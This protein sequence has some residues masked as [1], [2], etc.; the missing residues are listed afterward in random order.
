[1]GLLLLTNTLIAEY[2]ILG[3]FI[4]TM[5]MN[6]SILLPLPADLVVFSA[7]AL[8][9]SSIFF[10][11]LAIGIVA[12]IGSAIG[13]L[14]SWAV[15]WETDVLV[16]KKRHGKTYLLVKE[17]FTRYGFVGIA[18]FAL[19]PLPLDVM[20]LFA[21]AVRYSPVKYFTATL[22]GKIPRAI[23]LAYAGLSGMVIVLKF[24]QGMP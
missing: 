13:E 16:L 7:G 9:S 6:A 5:L 24:F 3:V 1:M 19:T 21:G 10:N 14:T 12:G 20:G 8:S 11:P 22:L 23:I 2:G 4:S 18:F 15:G 17:F